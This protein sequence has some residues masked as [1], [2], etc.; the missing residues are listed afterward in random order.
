MQHFSQ[1]VPR[2]CTS[3]LFLIMYSRGACNEVCEELRLGH[4]WTWKGYKKVRFVVKYRSFH[5]LFFVRCKPHCFSGLC[6]TI[7]SDGRDSILVT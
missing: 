7:C 1:I 3:V 2:V 6:T 5:N 4:R